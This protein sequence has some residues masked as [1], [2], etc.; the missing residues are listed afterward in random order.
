L[1]I[2]LESAT[3]AY[4]GGLGVR[5]GRQRSLGSCANAIALDGGFFNAQRTVE[6]YAQSVYRIGASSS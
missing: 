6:K 3:P 2:E 1:A 4:A 5:G